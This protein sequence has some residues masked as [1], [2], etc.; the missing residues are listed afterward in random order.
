MLIDWSL[1]WLIDILDNL[2]ANLQTAR[3]A[4]MAEKRTWTKSSARY[5]NCWGSD[6]RRQE[7]NKAMTADDERRGAGIYRLIKV[8]AFD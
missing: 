7:L 4:N 6:K 5:G 1:E 3:E 2:S 8:T